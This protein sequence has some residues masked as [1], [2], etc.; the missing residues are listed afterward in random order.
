MLELRLG[1]F[2]HLAVAQGLVDLLQLSVDGDVEAALQARAEAL[3]RRHRAA[4]LFQR[5]TSVTRLFQWI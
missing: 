4:V 5:E 3:Q 2:T 1:G